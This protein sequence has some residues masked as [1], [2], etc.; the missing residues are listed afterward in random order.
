ML[1][2]KMLADIELLMIAGEVKRQAE[3]RFKTKRVAVKVRNDGYRNMS[4]TLIV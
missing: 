2:L 1:S 4:M 3:Y